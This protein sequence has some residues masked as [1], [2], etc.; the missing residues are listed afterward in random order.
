[1]DAHSRK[2]LTYGA[3]MDQ[4]AMMQ[5]AAVLSQDEEAALIKAAQADPAEFARVYRQF[6]KPV[7]RY[8]YNRCGDAN[9]AEDLTAQTFL[10]AFEG[11]YRY[12]PKGPFAAWLFTIARRRSIDHLRRRRPVTTL[13]EQDR[14]VDKPEDPLS[15]VILGEESQLLLDEI[16]GLKES[17]KELLRLRFAA[18]LSFGEI[19]RLLRRSE[20]AVKMSL[21]RLLRRLESQ[22]EKNHE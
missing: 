15:Q 17:E 3:K 8:L 22:L 7:Y 16:A 18:G 4:T 13:T 20:A 1:M 2:Q 11:L 6:V 9:D 12:R 21:Y 5:A 10:E 14:T 19:A